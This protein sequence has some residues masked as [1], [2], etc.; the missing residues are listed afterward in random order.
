MS[1]SFAVL[2]NWNGDGSTFVDE[3]A[4]LFDAHLQIGMHD[5][6]TGSEASAEHVN[7]SIDPMR[8]GVA[9]FGGLIGAMPT[10]SAPGGVIAQPEMNRGGHHGGGHGHRGG[11]H[12]ASA[13]THAPKKP[14]KPHHYP[15]QIGHQPHPPHH[16]VH[17]PPDRGPIEYVAEVGTCTLT[18]DNSSGRYSPDNAGGP[19]YGNLLPRR[20]VKVTASDGVTN[21]TLFAGYVDKIEPEAGSY[22]ARHVIIECIDA[23]GLLAFQRISLPLQQNMTAD[24]LISQVVAATYTPASTNYQTG[25]TPFDVAAD[26]WSADRTTALDAIKESAESEF[27]RFFIQ[28]DGTPTFYARRYFFAPTTPV[29]SLT[30]SNPFA[31]TVGRDIAQVFNLIKVVAHPRNTLSMIQVLASATS[32]VLIPPIGPLGAG[33]RIV[34]LHFHDATGNPIGGTTLQIPLTATTDYVVN[35]KKDNSGVYYT[36]S[37]AFTIAVTDVRGSEITITMT[38]AALGVLYANTLQIRGQAITSYDPVT[39]TAQDAAS[40]TAYQKREWTHDLPLSADVDFAQSLAAYLL[41]RYAQPFTRVDAVSIHN[42]PVI[43]GTNVFSVKL[44]DQLTVSD[45]QTGLS[46]VALWVIGLRL[47]I[48]PDDFLITYVTERSD[49]RVWWILGTSPLGTNT[50]LAV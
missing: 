26:Q 9:G 1:I 42:D 7:A 47:Q 8:G 14:P 32:S 5:R 40:Q 10:T 41:D 39:Q 29:L 33:I 2:V 12:H 30:T 45:P 36:T 20:A 28:R 25:A 17:V 34:T 50:R 19:L 15:Y 11:G 3:S 6:Y 48:T 49:D 27:G 16:K 37:P 46:N 21:W 43:N 4:Y 44:F 18:L 38:N 13:R 22:S 23:I 31:L 35:E 24:Q